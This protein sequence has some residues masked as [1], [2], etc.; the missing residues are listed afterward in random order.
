MRNNIP[1][2]PLFRAISFA[3][4]AFGICYLSIIPERLNGE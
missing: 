3:T 2:L 4:F 1:L